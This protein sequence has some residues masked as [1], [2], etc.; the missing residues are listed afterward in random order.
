MIQPQAGLSAAPLV[1]LLA[2]LALPVPG[3]AAPRVDLIDLT[4]LDTARPDGEAL[5]P[6][7]TTR[8]GSQE[9]E[10]A[11]LLVE[12]T[13]QARSSAELTPTEVGKAEDLAGFEE[14]YTR[15]TKALGKETR[16]SSDTLMPLGGNL[17]ALR[18]RRIWTWERPEGRIDLIAHR[19]DFLE[20]PARTMARAMIA[21]MRRQ[22]PKQV[23]KEDSAIQMSMAMAMFRQ[24]QAFGT[25]LEV[26]AWNALSDSSFGR[27]L[28]RC[29][30]ACQTDSLWDLY[31]SDPGTFELRS[32]EAPD[33]WFAFR[34]D[35]V[36][37]R[38]ESSAK[39]GEG[40]TLLLDRHV[41][42]LDPTRTLVYERARPDPSLG[43]RALTAMRRQTKDQDFGLGPK[44]PELKTVRKSLD[45]TLSR[46]VPGMVRTLFRTRR[47]AV[48]FP[49]PSEPEADLGA[50]SE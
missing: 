38:E 6:V 32:A 36:S 46:F 28:A 30:S 44:S 41:K 8:I 13:V 23:A 15:L 5:P 27:A 4:S 29:R 42:V 35:S 21:T 10:D 31:A 47:L 20:A 24:G 9:E 17:F 43:A 22:Q 37:M 33:S 50:V 48:S 19:T 34:P 39:L 2:I 12:G 49:V 3:M 18:T 26:R 1:L 45:E 14:R 11:F 7:A 40:T 25:R 16:I